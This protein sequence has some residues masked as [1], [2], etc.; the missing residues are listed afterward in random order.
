MVN[1]VQLIGNLGKDPETVELKSG[2][3][4]T[5]L[6]LAT[7]EKKFNK[8]TNSYDN[9]TEWHKIVVFDQNAMFAKQL[10]KGY[11]VYIEGRLQTRNWIDKQGNK[12]Y[13]TEVCGF[14][15]K[16]LTHKTTQEYI[17]V[18]KDSDAT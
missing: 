11:M 9:Y 2:K 16:N 7:T 13:T 12:R 1:K 8:L 4:I 17:D 3:L 15:L 5:N 6:N 18:K 10:K 14:I